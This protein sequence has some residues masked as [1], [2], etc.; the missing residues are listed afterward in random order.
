MTDDAEVLAAALADRALARATLVTGLA[1]VVLGMVALGFL[2]LT[3][4]RLDALTVPVV[5]LAGVGQLTG[6]AAAARCAVALRRARSG[7]PHRTE[8][9]AAAR[10]IRGLALAAAVLAAVVAAALVVLLDP[11]S[12]AVV[13]V[14]LGAGLLAQAVLVLAVVRGPLA[15]A[16]R[17][18]SAT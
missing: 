3:G 4:S 18:P 17:A 15:R 9:G 8:A 7:R 5:V 11:L 13:G 16:A 2:L 1:G 6:L 14:A 10:F 12:G